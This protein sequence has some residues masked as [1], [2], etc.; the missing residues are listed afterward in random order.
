MITSQE[1]MRQLA[2]SA[3]AVLVC[4]FLYKPLASANSGSESQSKL[5][6][7]ISSLPLLCAS[8]LACFL[9][10]RLH[11]DYDIL[12]LAVGAITC[13]FIGAGLNGIFTGEYIFSIFNC[14]ATSNINNDSAAY[15]INI[16]IFSFCNNTT[17]Q[18][19]Y[20]KLLQL[21]FFSTGIVTN[22]L[23]GID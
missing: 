17:I 19:A 2:C 12:P 8:G 1:S 6:C 21:N 13:G 22:H 18:S 3:A 11:T 16:N 9:G 7:N 10:P 14:G 4:C 23:L 20:T 15:V 5:S